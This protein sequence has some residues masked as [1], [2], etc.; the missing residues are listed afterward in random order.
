MKGYNGVAL[1]TRREPEWVSYGLSKG[2]NRKELIMTNRS[3]IHEYET[4]GDGPRLLHA[5]VDGVPIVNTYIPQGFRIDDITDKL[6]FFDETQ[7]TGRQKTTIDFQPWL[8]Y[9]THA[10][11]EAMAGETPGRLKPMPSDYQASVGQKLEAVVF[12]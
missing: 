7:N 2:Y 11:T 5:V 4:G 3:L 1:F 8:A 12:L 6:S 10:G 9:G